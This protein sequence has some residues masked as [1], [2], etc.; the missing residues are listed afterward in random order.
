M[1]G[2]V[3]RKNSSNSSDSDSGSNKSHKRRKITKKRNKLKT[4]RE[5][6]VGKMKNKKG[7]SKAGVTMNYSED[8]KSEEGS[9][10]D[11][12][13]LRTPALVEENSKLEVGLI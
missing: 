12:E 4:I 8:E 6:K 10:S 5:K 1:T 11:E 13:N 2:S 3:S 9:N 7:K